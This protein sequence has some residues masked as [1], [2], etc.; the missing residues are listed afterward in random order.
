MAVRTQKISVYSLLIGMFVYK[1]DRPWA[2]TKYP[3][4]GFY[5]TNV[6]E[7]RKL[8]LVCR[9]VYIDEDKSNDEYNKQQKLLRNK[10]QQTSTKTAVKKK[11]L[12]ITNKQDY[13]NVIPFKKVLNKA[14][15]N[16]Q[17]LHH[18]V[19]YLFS[20]I[21]NHNMVKV[22]QIK[23]VLTATVDSM[24]DNPDALMWVARTRDNDDYTYNF[25]LKQTI[26]A[27]ATARE[28]GMNK[29]DME[30]MA[31]ASILSGIGKSK[32]PVDIL[33]KENKLNAKQFSVYQKHIPYTVRILKQ[34]K[35]IH[36]QVIHIVQNHC[37]YID[38]SGYPNRLKGGDIYLASQIIGLA[39]FYEIHSAPRDLSR[40]ISANEALD[41]INENKDKKFNAELVEN[42]VQAIGIYPTGTLVQL[43]NGEIAVIVETKEKQQNQLRLSP[44]IIVLRN[45]MSEK[46]S[47]Q[48]LI[49][50]SSPKNKLKIVQ[51]LAL[52]THDINLS[53]INEAVFKYNHLWSL[54]KAIGF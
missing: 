35:N 40:A 7:I 3:L 49:K 38:G 41:K 32:L 22:D 4:E 54:K 11:T 50:L 33:L 34:M 6:D 15:K 25:V 8:K 9:Y 13:S 10:K 37:E 52:G 2:D 1:L 44:N 28:L 14:I 27:L 17:Q 26:W 18:S 47:K 53:E 48:R 19:N 45:T 23:Q 24:I 51:S 46:N 43:D 30:R 36:P 31:L 29:A 21:S 20:H 16:H 39:A 42:F 5:I 12:K